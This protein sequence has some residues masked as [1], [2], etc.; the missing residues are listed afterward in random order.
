MTGRSARTLAS[1]A[2]L[3]CCAGIGPVSAQTNRGD[4]HARD[5]VTDYNL[6]LGVECT[7]CHVEGQWHDD[8]KAPKQV[9]Q[10]M[11]AM[12][13]QLNAKLRGVGEVRC[14]T[15]HAGQTQ[16]AALPQPAIE[17]EIGRWPASIASAPDAV[18]LRMAMYSASTGLRCGQCHDVTNW[19]RVDT[20]RMRTVPRMLSL[21]AIIQPFVRA[22]EVQCFTCHK[23]SSKPRKDAAKS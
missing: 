2:A 22:S 11:A 5:R 7:Y 16:P 21:F 6:A 17:A 9:T 18:K 8:S 19:K 14:W 4:S 15:C 23:G 1:V 12:T 10:Q 3:W 13:A 20:D